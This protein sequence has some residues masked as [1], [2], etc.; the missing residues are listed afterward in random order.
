[1][2]KCTTS[3]EDIHFCATELSPADDRLSTLKSTS[4]DHRSFRDV[5]TITRASIL[6]RVTE[7]RI[8][9]S[10]LCLNTASEV[11]TQQQN[12]DITSIVIPKP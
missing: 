2:Q 8:S 4:F 10:V 7:T 5:L 9:L 11:V 1:M 6:L 3:V 12:L